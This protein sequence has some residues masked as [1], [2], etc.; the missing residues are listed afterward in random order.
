MAPLGAISVHLKDME[1]QVNLRSVYAGKR[2]CIIGGAL[3]VAGILIWI[4]GESMKGVAQAI[5]L[6]AGGFAFLAGV[7]LFAV[8]KFQHWYPAA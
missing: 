1:Q 2:N 8:G 7:V 5:P 4:A 3:V 6:T